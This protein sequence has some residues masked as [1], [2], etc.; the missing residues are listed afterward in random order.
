VLKGLNQSRGGGGDPPGPSPHFNDWAGRHLSSNPARGTFTSC[1][2]PDTARVRRVITERLKSYFS[3]AGAAAGRLDVLRG[4][5]G[6]VCVISDVKQNSCRGQ[7]D[8]CVDARMQGLGPGP[9]DVDRINGLHAPCQ[10]NIVISGRRMLSLLKQSF[11]PLEELHAGT[12]RSLSLIR[13]MGQV[14]TY[15]VTQRRDAGWL[16]WESAVTVTELLLEA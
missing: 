14:G 7:R 1:S 16:L 3:S 12:I 15:C 13:E 6:D 4:D 2:T 9:P 11:D 8:G 10:Q 5:D